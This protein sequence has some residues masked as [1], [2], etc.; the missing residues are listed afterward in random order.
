MKSESVNFENSLKN[1][2]TF[3]RKSIFFSGFG[4]I[5]K[6]RNFLGNKYRK[7]RKVIQALQIIS[8]V[9]L[10]L[11]LKLYLNMFVQN[12]YNYPFT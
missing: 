5:S 2:N 11:S 1:L 12:N 6:F 4:V 7:F 9:H 10:Y 8:T 3:V